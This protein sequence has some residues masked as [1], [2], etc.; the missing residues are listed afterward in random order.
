MVVEFNPEIR[1]RIRLSV[2]AYAYEVQNNPIMSDADFDAL[3]ESIDP[4]VLTGHAQIDLFFLW[5]FS[6]ETGIWIHHH[7]ELAEVG[8]VYE[9]FYQ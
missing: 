5:D 8:R 6:P 4:Q 1:N 7:P 2:A 9:E 3:A